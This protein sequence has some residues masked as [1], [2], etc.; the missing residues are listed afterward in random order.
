MTILSRHSSPSLL[1]IT[2]TPT[3][4]KGPQQP[5]IKIKKRVRIDGFSTE[6]P[7]SYELCDEIQKDLWWTKEEQEDTIKERTQLVTDFLASKTET[8]TKTQQT[9]HAYIY[10][11]QLSFSQAVRSNAAKQYLEDIST[12]EGLRG[13]ESKFTTKNLHRRHHASAV[14]SIERSLGGKNS[15]KDRLLAMKSTQSSKQSQVLAQVLASFDEQEW[16]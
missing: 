9:L 6:Y 5:I 2:A 15:S 1:V 12:I 14:L 7:P 8:A 4:K 3:T 10:G 11:S 16:L 13:L